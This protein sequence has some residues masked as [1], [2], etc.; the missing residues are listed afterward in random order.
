MGTNRKGEQT[1]EHILAV[2]RKLFY[3]N[4]YKDTTLSKM[5][6][7][8]QVPIGLIPYHFENKDNIV[9][10]VYEELLEQ[11]KSCMHS[12][13]K[14]KYDNYILYHAVLSRIYYQVILSDPKNRRFYYENLS[15]KSNY[16]ILNRVIGKAYKRYMTDFDITL[17]KEDFDDIILADFGARREFF[18][19]HLS[20]KDPL[21]IQKMV[22]F[23]NSI[24][25]RLLKLDPSLVDTIMASSLEIY[26]AIDFSEIR[27]LM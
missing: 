5:S 21:D 15:K 24:V 20:T 25:P 18:L 14:I 13:S 19:H 1:K 6:E 9:G 23:A 3:E 16:R 22:T 8:A 7:A 10:I 12:H 11:I 26:K 27:F 2:A 17:S 4:G